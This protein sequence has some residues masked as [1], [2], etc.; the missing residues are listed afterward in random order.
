MTK[1]SNVFRSFRDVQSR[2]E[3]DRRRAAAEVHAVERDIRVNLGRQDDLWRQLAAV[4]VDRELSLPRPVR[5]ALEARDRGIEA[6]RT[7]SEAIK[8]ELSSLKPRAAS[9]RSEIADREVAISG[10]RSAIR[11][12]FERDPRVVA[13][14]SRAAEID[15]AAA[16][17]SEKLER[18]TREAADKLPDYESDEL[19]VYLRDRDYGTED[20]R[21]RAWFPPARLLDGWLARVTDYRTARTAY[22]RLTSAPVWVRERIDALTPE[23]TELEKSLQRLLA[24]LETRLEPDLL[25]LRT[26]EGDLAA[27]EK[28]IDDRSDRLDSFNRELADAALAEDQALK[29]VIARYSAELADR[30]LSDM[31][32]LADRTE[33]EED[34]RIVREIEA[35]AAE[36]PAIEE[37]A[38]AARLRLEE[39]ERRADAF[40]RVVR[41][42]RNEGWDRPR[43]VF[44]NIDG[45]HLAAL[46]LADALTP[47]SV[48]SQLGAAHYRESDPAVT[49]WGGGA[50][51]SGGFGGSD[52][53]GTSGG[54]GGGDSFTTTGGF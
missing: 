30:G 25:E 19:F 47:N 14:R 29:N 9:L 6:L 33:T 13:L 43:H 31:A 54:F 27:I 28:D 4:H 24:E 38:A 39:A 45:G 2:A 42:I 7:S 51:P 32:A 17:L 21:R 11:A 41:R 23:R 49:P 12:D 36:L 34:D 40:D 3:R 46:L 20:Y 10:K 26:L 44:R 18:A 1:G 8:D 48:L 5:E 53:F 35:Q 22:D 16:R 15:D 37:R 50:S 52:G